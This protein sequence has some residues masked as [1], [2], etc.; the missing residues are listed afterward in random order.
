MKE[1]KINLSVGRKRDFEIEDLVQRD[2]GGAK[3]TTWKP[4][5]IETQVVQ[6]SMKE[7]D[8][9]ENLNKPF[10]FIIFPFFAPKKKRN[11]NI[12]YA[13]DDIGLEFLAEIKGKNHLEN[14]NN[15]QPSDFERNVF[16][17][18]LHKFQIISS[19]LSNEM[20]TTVKKILLDENI[21]DINNKKARIRRKEIM[22]DLI[23][24]KNL[25]NKK[26]EFNIEEILAYLNLKDSPK[27]YKRI[28]E[29]LYNLQSTT[30]SFKIRNKR[31][32]KG[33]VRQEIYSEPLNL[34]KYYKIKEKDKNGRWRV[35]YQITLSRNIFEELIIKSYSIFD[36]D[37]LLKIRKENQPSEKLYQY[38]C[39][40]RYNNEYEFSIET[41][42]TIAGFSLIGTITK[43]LKDGTEKKFKVRQ[44]SK[45][46]KKLEFAY[47]KLVDMGY[48]Q[49]YE[50]IE[51]EGKNF[52]FK[53]TFNDQKALCH[54]TDFINVIPSPDELE[55]EDIIAEFIDDVFEKSIEK[56][57][58]NI[59][60]EKK[61][62]TRVKKELK[63]IYESSGERIFKELTNRIYKGLNTEIK[64]SLNS[65]IK[66]V[67]NEILKD[68]ETLIV[69]EYEKSILEKENTEEIN[70]EEST[71]E[72]S[73]KEI[74]KTEEGLYLKMYNALPM[75]AKQEVEK[76]AYNLYIKELN[77][78]EINSVHKKIY[79]SIK[80][81]YIVRV[82][83]GEK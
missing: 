60:F 82:L 58:K 15:Q 5:E 26:I 20:K 50:V 48:L 32:V 24:E 59:Y 10:L 37:N 74:V 77:T 27:Y 28:E 36:K 68:K 41:I 22:L 17:F 38:I 14:L 8:F 69:K 9:R 2:I 18:I 70:I 57:R 67:L 49:D 53:H 6:A 61:Y 40:K 3:I 35:F 13:Y 79:E 51:K 64:K 47:Q 29:A 1:E 72:I 65:Y 45:I 7:T 78:D 66:V 83:K 46:K 12:I 39:M 19:G 21:L 30:Y 63:I 55:K 44:V 52:S 34:I 11:I 4:Q 54:K 81:A 75:L 42:S 73:E 71:N 33:I 25:E 31:K 62:N 23:K 43:K 76:V 80:D 56:L 16:E